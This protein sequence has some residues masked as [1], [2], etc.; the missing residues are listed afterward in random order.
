MTMA[1]VTRK[2]IVK[3]SNSKSPGPSHHLSIRSLSSASVEGDKF[4]AR[5]E[6]RGTGL[7]SADVPEGPAEVTLGADY[8]VGKGGSR[9]RTERSTS[10]LRVIVTGYVT[11]TCLVEL[12]DQSQRYAVE[13]IGARAAEVA[14]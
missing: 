8:I 4:Y 9:P 12:T 11:D 10:K 6:Q 3:P 1:T 13:I 2:I 5:P 7:A 14:S